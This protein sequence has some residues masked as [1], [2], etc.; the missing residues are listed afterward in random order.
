MR[1]WIHESLEGSRC[2]D[3]GGEERKMEKQLKGEGGNINVVITHADWMLLMDDLRESASRFC[4]TKLYMQ[5]KK[6]KEK[7]D[8]LRRGQAE[9]DFFCLPAS[10][11]AKH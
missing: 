11:T 6:T 10:L 5:N 2:R 8:K 4:F 9:S 7:W 3:K 1:S